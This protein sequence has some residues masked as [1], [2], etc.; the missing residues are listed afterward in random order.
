MTRR[1]P[2][3]GGL[4]WDGHRQRWIAIATVGYDGRGKRIRRK[5]SGRTKTE[6]R[7]KLRNLLREHEDGQ[8][9]SHHRLTVR[10]AVE[11]WL[12]YGLANRSAAT[13]SKYHILCAKH[14]IPLLGGAVIVR[15]L[16]REQQTGLLQAM[17]RLRVV[18]PSRRQACPQWCLGPPVKVWRSQSPGLAVRES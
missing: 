4:F 16:V 10:L 11:D 17:A 3:D 6:A 13:V 15:G 7:A 12:A 5:T 9:L 2:G 1:A 14:I 18:I 8:A